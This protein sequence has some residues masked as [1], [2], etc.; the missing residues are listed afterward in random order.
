MLSPQPDKVAGF[1]QKLFSWK[2][3]NAN[4]LGYRELRPGEEDAMNGGIWPA[5]P[6]SPT[7]VQLIIEVEDI[8]ATIAKAEKVG[9]KVLVPK[10]ILPDGDV[11][12]AMQDPCGMSFGLCTLKRE[13]V[14]A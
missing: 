8:D 6:E 9:A 11:M 13:P 12:A 10:S 3:A 4:A 1:Y 14:T 2:V 7:F 5:P